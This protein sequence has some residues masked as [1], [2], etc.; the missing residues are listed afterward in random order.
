MERLLTSS[1]VGIRNW[2]SQYPCAE[3]IAWVAR[4]GHS[5][6]ATRQAHYCLHHRAR[7]G[8]LRDLP[9]LRLVFMTRSPPFLRVRGAD[10]GCWK[11]GA[12]QQ[13]FRSASRGSSYRA[14]WHGSESVVLGEMLFSPTPPVSFNGICTSQWPGRS[15][16]VFF[17]H[18]EQRPP[19]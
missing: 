7:S 9:A 10:Q 2:Q 4:W 14:C 13:S 15:S 11:V 1:T 3:I 5:G 6:E 18:D 8:S 12:R 17:R 16:Q 19:E